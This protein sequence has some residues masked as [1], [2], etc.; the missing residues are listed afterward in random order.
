M[1]AASTRWE[2]LPAPAILSLVK[3]L[4]AILGVL[5]ACGGPPSSDRSGADADSSPDGSA[6]EPG[7][8]TA[9]DSPA[10]ER[11]RAPDG[12]VRVRTEMRHAEIRLGHGVVLAVEYL[13]GVMTAEE[14]G[15][16]VLDDRFS[17]LLH[18]DTAEA[19]LAWPRLS[20]LL[21]RWVFAYE[22]APLQDLEVRWETDEEGGDRLAVSGNLSTAG[23]VP[24]EIEAVPEV[25]SDGRLLLRTRSIQSV[26]VGVGGILDLFGAETDDLV[27]ARRA[28][29]VRVRGDDLLL[30]PAR[31][32]PPPRMRGRLV[33]FR[34]DAERAV[35]VFG[36]RTGG[37]GPPEAEIPVGSTAGP[38]TFPN[39]LLYRGGIS[40]VGRL[41]MR[42]TDIRIVD[43]DTSDAFDFWPARMHRQL[44]AGHVHMRP[45]GGLMPVTPDFG[46]LPP[47]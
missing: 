46:D 40:R 19:S 23:G 31:M 12:R 37:D 18:V 25:T 2:S 3:I 27:Q 15:P 36:G 26:G 22:G 33:A 21:D 11:L 1:S 24:F 29:G 34:P 30:S 32:L 47:R 35:L 8:R 7:A 17:Y 44:N 20:D 13:R 28:R 9:A 39:Y 6:V 41:T 14:G 4:V 16:V 42:D 5:L 10:A 43:A 38:D 45:D